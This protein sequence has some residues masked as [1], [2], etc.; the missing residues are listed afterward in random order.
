MKVLYL[1]NKVLAKTVEDAENGK[2]HD[3]WLFGMLRLRKYGITTDF[4][5]IEKYIPAKLGRLLRAHILTMH[6]AHIP[7]FPLFFRYDVVFTST[8]YGCMVLKALFRIRRFKWVVLD[9]NIL[10]TIQEEKTLRE[11]IFAWAL[12]KVD[13]IVAISKIEA[14][15]LKKRFPHLSDR[16][17]FLHEATDIDFFKPDQTIPQRNMIISVGN[18]GRDFDTLIEAVRGLPVEVC[19]ATKLISVEKLQVLPSNVTARLYNHED[20]LRLY[21]EAKIAFIGIEKKD[22]YFDSV[23]T[24]AL[25]EALAMGKATIATHMKSMESYIEHGVTGFFVPY[26]DVVALR[27]QI[28][29]LLQDDALRTSVGN[30]AYTFARKA[31]DPEKFAQGVAEFM[32]NTVMK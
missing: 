29:T 14:D 24:L 22:T 7:L 9:F 21:C 3:S 12:S 23:G 15:A 25:G 13:G 16:I 8:A 2:G 31:L 6:Y 11:K 32:K 27:L 17:V 18:Y 19:L 1:F 26:K 20:M 10:G 4:L 30:K 28:E 5:E